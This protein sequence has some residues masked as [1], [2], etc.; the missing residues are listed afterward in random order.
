MI[1]HKL[2]TK[3]LFGDRNCHLC[4]SPIPEDISFFSHFTQKHAPS[5]VDTSNLLANLRSQDSDPNTIS[6]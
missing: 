2:L 3:P 1:S 6:F 4:D 5:S